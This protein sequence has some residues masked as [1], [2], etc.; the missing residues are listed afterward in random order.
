MPQTA[1]SLSGSGARVHRCDEEKSPEI[2]IKMLI[3]GAGRL[4]KIVAVFVG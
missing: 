3:N 4:R 1:F 2:S